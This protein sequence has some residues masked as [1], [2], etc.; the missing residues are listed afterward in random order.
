MEI[1]NQPDLMAWLVLVK[2]NARRK[3]RLAHKRQIELE[4]DG[5]CLAAF[6]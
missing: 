1:I 4:Q 6:R 5:I 2:R 3:L